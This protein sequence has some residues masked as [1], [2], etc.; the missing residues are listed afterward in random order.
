MSPLAL[1]LGMLAL[2]GALGG[3]YW[4]GRQ[5][6]HAAELAEAVRDEAV[7]A[8]ASEAAASAAAHAIAG[9]TITHRTI[10]Q[11]VQR[12]IRTQEVYRDPDCRTG[13][14]SLRQY[15]A[16]IPAEPD[17]AARADPVAMPASH[18]RD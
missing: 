5:D 16:T 7:A 6:G 9:L 18:A 1:A 14:D 10:N 15:N 8:I 4:Q 11:E 17:G 13:P 2:I 3:A 12:E